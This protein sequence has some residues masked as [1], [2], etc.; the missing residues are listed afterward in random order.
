MAFPEVSNCLGLEYLKEASRMILQA[1]LIRGVGR[2][3]FFPLPISLYFIS[4]PFLPFFLPV[5][6]FRATPTENGSS[7][8]KG[9]SGAVAAGLR[10]RHSNAESH[11]RL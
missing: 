8:A 3:P 7:Q 11:P 5:C 4:F 9:Q 6:L 1:F 10:H 2:D